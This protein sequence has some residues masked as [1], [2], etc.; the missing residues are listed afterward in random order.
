MVTKRDDR[1]EFQSTIR[2]FLYP[3]KRA[4]H[5]I[6]TMFNMKEHFMD[7]ATEI[8]LQSTLDRLS[9]DLERSRERRKKF[10]GETT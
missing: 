2:L 9:G 8:D 10:N 7:E 6:N 1:K 5:N 3:A 4:S